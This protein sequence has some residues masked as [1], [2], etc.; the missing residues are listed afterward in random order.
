MFGGFFDSRRPV[1]AGKKHNGAGT[2]DKGITLTQPG[3]AI[4]LIISVCSCSGQELKEGTDYTAVWSNESS[5]DAGTYTVTF[6]VK[7]K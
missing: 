1:A 4:I 5:Q 7:I 3:K 6:K 2:N